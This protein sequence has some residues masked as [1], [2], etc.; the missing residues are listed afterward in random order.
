MITY[1]EIYESARKERY[2]EQLQPLPKNFIA[3]VAEYLKEK[4]EMSMKEDDSFS[5]MITKTKKQFENAVT[6]F[7]ELKRIRRRKILN[8]V[9]VAS[10]TG[11]SKRDFENML[12]FEKEL[13]EE[14][15]KCIEASDKKFNGLLNGAKNEVMKNEMVMFRDDVEEFLGPDGEMMGGFMKGQI[16]NLPH[17]IAQILI[18][19]GKA[20]KVEE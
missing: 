5:D 17:Q 2:S 1:N 9:L 12:D 15:M 14:L 8:L 11:I 13:F 6:L 10:E 20:E 7:N 3:S 4:K 19:D 18:E 16:A